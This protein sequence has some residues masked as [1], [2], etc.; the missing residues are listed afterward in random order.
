MCKQLV[1]IITAGRVVVVPLSRTC[2]PVEVGFQCELSGFFLRHRSLQRKLRVR[3]FPKKPQAG[4]C[5]A[6]VAIELLRHVRIFPLGNL[7]AG[8]TA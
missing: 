6:K 1:F 4:H 5:A 7:N 2:D 3:I 8:K